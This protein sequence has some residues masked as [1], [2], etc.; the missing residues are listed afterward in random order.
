MTEQRPWTGH[1]FIAT[2]VDGYIARLDGG[3]DWLTD[4]PGPS[5][6][7]GYTEFTATIDHM[8]M[9]RG[10]YETV[11]A[12]DLWPYTRMKV[13]VLSSTLAAADDRITV[14][15]SLPE[16]IDTLAAAGAGRVYTDGGRVIQSCLAAG[17]IDDLVITRVPVLLGEGIPLFGA[18]PADVRLE[19]LGVAQIGGGMV[20]ERYAVVR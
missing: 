3:L 20:Q 8:L 9:G 11:A 15:R 6:D 1:V 2:S 17:L 4:R 14:V 12:F 7:G 5:G 19:T 10:T 16:A 18:P 13:I